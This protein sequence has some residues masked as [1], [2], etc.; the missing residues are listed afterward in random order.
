[1]HKSI[2]QYRNGKSNV[3]FERTWLPAQCDYLQ[4][5]DLNLYGTAPCVVIY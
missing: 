3:G 5:T 1:M 4:I 2:E